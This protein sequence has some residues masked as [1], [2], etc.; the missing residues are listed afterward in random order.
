MDMSKAKKILITIITLVITA[1]YVAGMS[2]IV[3]KMRTP[4]ITEPLSFGDYFVS[5]ANGEIDEDD[6]KSTLYNN[7]NA[8]LR[9]SNDTELSDLKLINL[10]K[11]YFNENITNPNATETITL[12]I[13]KNIATDESLK[14]IQI[15]SDK[16][17]EFLDINVEQRTR[18]NS[19]GED[20]EYY[21]VIFDIEE[22]GYYGLVSQ[23]GEATYSLV[24]F[25]LSMVGVVVLFLLLFVLFKP[26]PRKITQSK[27][28][29]SMNG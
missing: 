23:T 9:F 27:D 1:G 17:I 13:A 24:I 22:E 4:P 2:I 26:K 19:N 7:I 6:E 11:M 18:Q 3:E 25:I 14:L 29:A 12:E 8:L 10:Y 28:T 21:V 5:D 16:S 15:D 20:E